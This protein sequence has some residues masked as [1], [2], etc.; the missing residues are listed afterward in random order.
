MMETSTLRATDRE[1]ALACGD[2]IIRVKDLTV[3]W[4]DVVLQRDLSFE[5]HEGEIFA[6][7]GGSGCGKSTLL[8]YLIGLEP[9]TTGEVT[10]CG[11]HLDELPYGPPPF[12][13]TFQAGALFGSS[14]VGENVGLPLEEWTDLP[15]EAISA[16]ARAKLRLVGLDGA[17]SKFPSELSGG[18]RKRAAIA[19]ALALEPK[20]VFL[21]EPTTGLDPVT[22]AEVEGLIATLNRTL[23]LTFVV[24]THELASILT[25]V[26]RAIMLDK[27]AKS[28]IAIGEPH[29][30]AQ[31]DD[32]RVSDFFNRR[33]S[34]VS[35]PPERPERGE[36]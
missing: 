14:T 9:V 13:V 34:R 23:G 32:Q 7:L 5:V 1:G 20:I 27:D 25:I 19:R 26:Q 35:P 3:G 21:D 15:S 2:P 31:S 24:V 28:A 17:Y 33:P 16:V 10:I 18:M 8:R 36:G 22:A 4:G 6:I 30:L 12:G 11:R 29:V